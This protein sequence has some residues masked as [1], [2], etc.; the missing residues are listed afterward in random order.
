MAALD[1]D[2]LWVTYTSGLAIHISWVA[3]ADA[4]FEGGRRGR[5]CADGRST[6][7]RSRSN[8]GGVTEEDGKQNT[9]ELHIR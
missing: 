3:F 1:G 7:L 4:G 5:G 9:G 6:S 8:Q 2:I